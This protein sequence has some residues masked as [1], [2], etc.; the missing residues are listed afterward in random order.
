MKLPAGSTLILQSHYTAN[1]KATS[2]R[3]RIG[4]KF[5]SAKPQTEVRFASLINGNF[6]IPAGA[7][8]TASTPR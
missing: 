5:A 8:D 1:G 4:V 2:D 6:V 3:T 7:T